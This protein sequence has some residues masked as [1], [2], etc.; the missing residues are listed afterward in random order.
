[1]DDENN[2]VDREETSDA[3]V[4]DDQVR[5]LHQLHLSKLCPFLIFNF[6]YPADVTVVLISWFC[7]R[8]ISPQNFH[9]SQ[10]LLY[11]CEQF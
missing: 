3:P 2:L 5:V 6:W 7:I 4:E 10:P 1:M 9:S 8:F 11:I